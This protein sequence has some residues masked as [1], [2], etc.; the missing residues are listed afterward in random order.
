MKNEME[1]ERWHLDKTIEKLQKEV[2]EQEE[3]REWREGAR[4]GEGVGSSPSGG[5][6]KAKEPALCESTNADPLEQLIGLVENPRY[7]ETGLDYGSP[8]GFWA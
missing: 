8:S 3:A 6:M 7:R 2:R 1:N 5:L 4:G